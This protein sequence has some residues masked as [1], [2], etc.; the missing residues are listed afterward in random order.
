M[1]ELGIKPRVVWLQSS[2]SFLYILILS[3]AEH[4][5]PFPTVCLGWESLKLLVLTT[6]MCLGQEPCLPQCI[7]AQDSAECLGLLGGSVHGG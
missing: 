2:C 3:P 7:P 4:P 6:Q 1:V 5:C